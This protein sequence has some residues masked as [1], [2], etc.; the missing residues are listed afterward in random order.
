MIRTHLKIDA[1]AFCRHLVDINKIPAENIILLIDKSA[2]LAKLRSVLGTHLKNKAGKD[3]MVIIYF[4]GH[5]A[6]EKNVTGPDG[7]GLKKYLLPHDVN[8]KDLY[9]TALPMGEISRIFQRIQ[10]ERLIFIA[11]SCHSGASGGSTISLTDTRANISDDFLDRVATGKG[12]IILTASGANEVSAEKEELGHG[13]FTY[14]LL[15]GLK[16][17]ADTDKDGLITVDEAYQYVSKCVPDATNQ[18]QHP[19]KKGAVEGQLVLSIM[20]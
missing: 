8:P 3:D 5:G 15:D 13:V 2:S 18:T 1:K 6:T 12:K 20:E 19:V 17:K 14:F 4:A 16:G 7:D 11:D 10:S 9:A